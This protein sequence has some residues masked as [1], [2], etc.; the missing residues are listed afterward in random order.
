MIDILAPIFCLG[1]VFFVGYGVGYIHSQI[2]PKKK[3]TNWKH[4]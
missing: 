2:E 4:K 3:K 1:L